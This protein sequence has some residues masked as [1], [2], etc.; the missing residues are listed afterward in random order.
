MDQQFSATIKYWAMSNV[1]NVYTSGHNSCPQPK[2]SSI[3]RLIND[4]PSVNQTL[5]QLY[6]HLAQNVV[7]PTPV[8]LP[9]FCNQQD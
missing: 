5:P 6:Q 9:R 3:N 4:R 2:S 7:R 1:P 8:A